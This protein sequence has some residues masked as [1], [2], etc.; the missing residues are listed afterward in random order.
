MIHLEK[1][2]RDRN[3]KY[4]LVCTHISYSCRQNILLPIITMTVLYVTVISLLLIFCMHIN[5][6]LSRF[7][8]FLV[9]FFPTFIFTSLNYF[10]CCI[11]KFQ[12]PNSRLPVSFI[13]ANKIIL[14][15]FP[16]FF[17][18]RCILFPFSL[19]FIIFSWN[20]KSQGE[21]CILCTVHLHSKFVYK[22]T[23]KV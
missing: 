10:C 14:L 23:Q 1:C 3:T 4:N 16:F 18:S 2:I 6:V 5:S 19:F 13:M 15:E 9:Y 12:I 17:L 7:F 22:E 21:S 8:S 20:W 11:S